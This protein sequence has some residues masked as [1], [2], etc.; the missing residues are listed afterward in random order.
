M[1][2]WSSN[3]IWRWLVLAIWLI[4]SVNGLL[5]KSPGVLEAVE[6]PQGTNLSL[7]DA[8]NLGTPIPKEFRAD[9]VRQEK[10]FNVLNFYLNAIHLVWWESIY[11]FFASSEGDTGQF[12]KPPRISVTPSQAVY[13]HLQHCHVVWTLV[14][15]AEDC[16][17]THDYREIKTNILYK[18]RSGWN[19]LGTLLVEEGQPKDVLA[20]D[21]G[22]E[23]SLYEGA[24]PGAS[25]TPSTMNDDKMDIQTGFLHNGKKL[26]ST[27][28]FLTV[29]RAI[30]VLAEEDSNME[31]STWQFVDITTNVKV[32]MSAA[33]GVSLK[34]TVGNVAEALK[35]MAQ[36]MVVS[37]RFV[38]M[39]AIYSLSNP[40]KVEYGSVMI[41]KDEAAGIEVS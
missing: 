16:F 12:K 20:P 1:E 27:N 30:A 19:E 37:K 17:A 29:I 38:E 35:Y 22:A 14:K 28:V 32:K 26:Q 7:S 8:T 18:L 5:I 31:I 25:D 21:Q 39:I 2:R 10:T 34:I 40:K 41:L 36:D 6:L 4:V 9:I 23:S 13:P 24:H 33:A 11:P 3:V 15:I